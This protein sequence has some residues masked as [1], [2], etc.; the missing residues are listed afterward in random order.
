MCKGG[1][2]PGT[3]SQV[4][5]SQYTFVQRIQDCSASASS[6][7]ALYL[8]VPFRHAPHAA[9]VRRFCRAIQRDTQQRIRTLARYD[10]VQT[11]LVGGPRPSRLGIAGLHRALDSVREIPGMEAPVEATVEVHA[12]DL[13]PDDL[14]ALADAGYTRLSIRPLHRTRLSASTV[15]LLAAARE[16]LASASVDLRFGGPRPTLSQWQTLLDT[17]LAHGV[18]HVTLVEESG[19]PAAHA[20]EGFRMAHDRLAAAGYHPYELTH[21]A[22]RPEHASRHMMHQYAYGSILGIGPGAASLWRGPGADHPV[23]R[24]RTLSSLDRYATHL[25]RGASPLADRRRLS[26]RTRACEFLML[27]LRTADGLHL[28]TLHRRFG[29]DLPRDSGPLLQRLSD[30]GHLTCTNQTLRLTASGRALADG[31]IIAL[32]PS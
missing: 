7:S 10:P 13:T 19:G 5:P 9:A 24:T 18:P 31:I 22:R 23:F 15:A 32:L 8:N 25:V 1:N 28:P 16:V 29:I 11:L 30:A 6:V 2:A 17:A 27:R 12:A 26:R 3:V 20:S 4:H 21:W 14:P